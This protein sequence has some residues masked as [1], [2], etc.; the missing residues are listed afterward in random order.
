MDRFAY[1]I[2]G[3]LIQFWELIEWRTKNDISLSI[4]KEL[5]LKSV[6]RPTDL[7]QS[8]RW[9]TSMYWPHYAIWRFYCADDC[10]ISS[11]LCLYHQQSK[12]H[13]LLELQGQPLCLVREKY[14]SRSFMLPLSLSF[15]D[16]IYKSSRDLENLVLLL[17]LSNSITIM[18]T[19][20]VIIIFPR[21]NWTDRLNM[22][23]YLPQ[24]PVTMNFN[25]KGKS[26]QLS[27][28][29]LPMLQILRSQAVSQ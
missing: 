27:G 12:R 24:F 21:I 28:S 4:R 20:D 10:D 11:S 15:L 22:P 25:P 29:F 5:K 8:T 17:S 23:Q 9:K 1:R 13:T 19:K 26:Y 14:L 6:T 18:T 3:Y 2:N 7:Y 16:I